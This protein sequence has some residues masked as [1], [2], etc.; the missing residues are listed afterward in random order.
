MH[1]L[2]F[3]I[4]IRLSILF[5]L[6]LLYSGLGAQNIDTAF[7]YYKAGRY[8][9]AA[10]EFE[11]ILPFLQKIYGVNDTA[12]YTYYLFYTG[13]CFSKDHKYAR[14]EDYFLKAK[15]VCLKIFKIGKKAF[16]RYGTKTIYIPRDN[17]H[18]F[19]LYPL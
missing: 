1:K 19:N 3:N 14:A 16:F 4:K 11:K 17:F 18:M 9:R 10:M 13:D 6:S 12:N 2:S 5:T 15:D 8:E 7:K